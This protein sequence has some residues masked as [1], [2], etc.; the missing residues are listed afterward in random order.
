MSLGTDAGASGSNKRALD[1]R[2][3]ERMVKQKVMDVIGRPGVMF[4]NV[5]NFF[6]G[7]YMIM[8]DVDMPQRYPEV[9]NPRV[10]NP[11]IFFMQPKPN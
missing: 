8:I 3:L 10:L 7:S 1:D 11:A 6:V 4:E 9:L 5:M 2:Q